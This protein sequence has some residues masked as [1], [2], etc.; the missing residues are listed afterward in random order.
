[1]DLKDILVCLDATDAGEGRLRLAAAIA[2]EHHAHLSAAYL[3]PRSIPAGAV[4]PAAGGGP[5]TGAAWLPQS[6]SAP[7][8]ASGE[9][10]E[11]STVSLAD[12]IEERFREEVR[13]HAIEGDWHLFA[14]GEGDQLAEL[15][16]TV[17]LAIFGQNAPDDHVPAHFRP[18]DLVMASGRPALIVPYAG[19]FASVGRRVLVAWDGTR[20][21]SRALHDALPLIGNAAAVTVMTVRAHEAGTDPK[22]ASLDRVVRH[23]E[24]H[25]LRARPEQLVGSDISISDALL[26][27][28]ADLDIDLIVAGAYHHSRLREALFGGVSRDF[29][30][31]MTVPVLMS[32]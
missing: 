4:S 2:R 20:E 7:R 12:I 25:G 19:A 6:G 17:D 27:R 23:L 3:L 32:H 11:P 9:S 22:E 21:A 29:L 5:P 1:M 14:A 18:E 30:D 26:S 16:K 31:H 13:P 15:L 28:A 24:R 8:D 10:D